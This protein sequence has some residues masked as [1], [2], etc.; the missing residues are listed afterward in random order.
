MTSTE[1][2]QL[3]HAL[4][5]SALYPHPTEEIRLI[6]THIS[7][8]LLTGKY[9]YKIVKPLNLGFL[10]FSTLEKRYHYYFEELRL[11]RRL[12]GKMYLGVVPIYGSAA[13][14]CLHGAG[15]VFEYAVKMRQFE[16]SA[17]FDQLLA[18]EQLTLQLIK[19]TA[20][21]VAHFHQT[22]ISCPADCKYGRP[23]QVFSPVQENFDQLKQLNNIGVNDLP[24]QLA[25]WSK[26]EF[27]AGHDF[28]QKRKAAGFIRACHGDL[29]LGNIALLD[30]EII[31]FDGIGFN[32]SLYWIDVIN[33]VAFLVMDLEDHQRPDL[34]FHFL[35][36]YLEICGD[37]SAL[38]LLPFYLVYRAMVRAKISAIRASQSSEESEIKKDITLYHDYLDLAVR[39]TR[40]HK[41]FLLLMH[42]VSASGKSWLSDQIIDHVAAI[43]IRSDVERK[44]L[45]RVPLLGHSN[46]EHLNKLYSRKAGALTYDRLL[47]LSREILTAG[48]NVVVDATFLKRDE[49][50]MFQQ[51]ANQEG[52]LWHIISTTADKET[53]RERICRRARER[54]NVSDADQQVLEEQL[55]T[56][57]PLTAEELQKATIINTEDK[58]QVNALWQAKGLSWI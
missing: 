25:D 6:E 53:L 28:F 26:K 5:D 9:A 42:G 30:G 14:P 45:F 46:S 48:F 21:T 51:L 7:W 19:R 34:A 24:A 27:R 38:R 54:D 47:Q 36:S 3:L 1:S 22:L 40:A 35:N 15:P 49:R 55:R 23:D 52:V 50:R 17:I 37:Y 10:D 57:D 12:A 41:P 33:E 2:T 58:K 32:P 29:H 13:Q 11:N 16:Q 31:P 18:E 44:R 8:V 43:R 4:Q 20:Q 39:Y 56:R